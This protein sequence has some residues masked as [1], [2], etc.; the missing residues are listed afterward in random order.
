ML[1]DLQTVGLDHGGLV[2]VKHAFRTAGRDVEVNVRSSDENFEIHARAF[3]RAAGHHICAVI[4]DDNGRVIRFRVGAS[5]DAR[6]RTALDS[7]SAAATGIVEVA[8]Q[9]WG[10]AARG[11]H[12]ESGVAE[13]GFGLIRKSEIWADE[14]ARMYQQATAAQWSP[15]SAIPWQAAR[16]PAELEQ[17]TSTIMTYLVENENVALLVPTRFLGQLH[18]HF[19]EVMQLLA[20][21]I[22]DEARHIEVFSRRITANGRQPGLS[23]VGGQRSLQT[24]LEEPDFATASFLLS[25]LG[26]G[27]F[28]SLLWFLHKHAADE[29]TKTLCQLAAQ[30]EARHVAFAIAHLTRHAAHDA[31]VLGRLR[32]AAERRHT[33]LQHSAGLNE[34]VFDALCIL[35][36]GSLEPAA[37]ANGHQAVMALNAEMDQH[38]QRRLA[39]IGFSAAEAESI[40]AMH[41]RNFM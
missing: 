20:V 40:S 8:D 34:D 12:V 15:D 11:A 13:L 7:G 18:P 2:A 19:R 25:V 31:A 10:L 41:T 38:R 5:V 27:T 4:A 30:D 35:A 17:A 24:L 9:R 16:A 26:E 37:L 14:A 28:L 1:L 22:A 21:Q 36:A 32:S 29:A 6:D 3:A 39:R 33:T 23:T